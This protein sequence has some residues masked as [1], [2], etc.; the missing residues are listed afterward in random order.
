MFRRGG[1]DLVGEGL[2]LGVTAECSMTELEYTRS[3]RSSS[4]PSGMAQASAMST[5]IQSG[6]SSGRGV[7]LM[8][9][10]D[11]GRPGIRS[12]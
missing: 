12:Q 3:Y 8:R 5:R 10:N 4:I 11:S 9:C 2:A 7:K 6:Q 1:A